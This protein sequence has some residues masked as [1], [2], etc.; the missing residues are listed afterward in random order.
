MAW[1]VLAG[2]AVLLVAGAAA[3]A[4]GDPKAGETV[5]KKCA[6]CHSLAKPP[7]NGIGPSLV[8]VVGR[9]AGSGDGFKYSDAMKNATVVWDDAALD[10]YLKDPKGFIPNNKMVLAAMSKEAERADVIAY[11]KQAA[12]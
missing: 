2:L 7:K 5:F 3:A 11:L 10:A 9:K 12:K 4:E 8:G 6:A 1:R